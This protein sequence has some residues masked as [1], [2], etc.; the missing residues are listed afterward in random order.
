[1]KKARI[2]K[3]PE[4]GQVLIYFPYTFFISSETI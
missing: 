3:T 2:I 1:M 4:P